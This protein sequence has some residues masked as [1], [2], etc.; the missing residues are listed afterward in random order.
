MRSSLDVPVV[1][2]VHEDTP[3]D[4]VASPREVEQ[5][6]SRLVPAAVRLGSYRGR[7]Y[8]LC[9]GLDVRALYYNKTLLDQH[10]LAQVCRVLYNLN[11][12]TFVD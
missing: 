7:M 1:T 6:A 11:E 3:L 4:E 2:D 9:N 5:L 12:F 8:G 10:G